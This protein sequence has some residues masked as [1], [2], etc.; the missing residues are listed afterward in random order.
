ME[1]PV[2][3]GVCQDEKEGNRHSQGEG[4]SLVKVGQCWQEALGNALHS[5]AGGEPV[6]GA[7]ECGAQT[8]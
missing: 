1:P 8:C 2:T 3:D 5:R 7:E 6:A 4:T